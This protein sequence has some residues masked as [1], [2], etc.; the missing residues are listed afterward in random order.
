[1]HRLSFVFRQGAAEGEFSRLRRAAFSF[2]AWLFSIR[3]WFG[4]F[5]PRDVTERRTDL[6][7]ICLLF[8]AAAHHQS[9]LLIQ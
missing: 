9:S 2:A 8:R 3:L 4:G 1:L 7:A 5:N 6:L